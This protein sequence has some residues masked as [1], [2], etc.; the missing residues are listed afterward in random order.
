[1][2]GTEGFQDF[3]T[4]GDLTLNS[5]ARQQICDMVNW[6]L[7]ISTPKGQDV[8][9]VKLVLEPNSE[10]DFQGMFSIVDEVS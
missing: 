10:D 8:T 2:R 6:W 5:T 9:L 4:D 1:M 7:T 3:I